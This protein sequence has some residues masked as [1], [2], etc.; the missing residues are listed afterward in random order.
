LKSSKHQEYKNTISD[1]LKTVNL[2]KKETVKI[3]WL[4]KDEKYVLSFLLSFVADTWLIVLE[5]IF[6]EKYSLEV[7]N[8]VV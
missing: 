3:D 5:K 2:F 7:W 4:T 6:K 8:W 1:Y